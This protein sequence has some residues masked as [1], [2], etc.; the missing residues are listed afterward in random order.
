M[1][2]I[3]KGEEPNQNFPPTLLVFSSNIVCISLFSSKCKNFPGTRFLSSLFIP[4][5]EVKQISCLMSCYMQQASMQCSQQCNHSTVRL[6]QCDSKH[7][8]CC[9]T[10]YRQCYLCSSSMACCITIHKFYLHHA[11]LIKW[12]IPCERTLHHQIC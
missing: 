6:C 4:G 8:C 2:A 10:L 5:M 9:V 3:Y 11:W 12:L 1:S 7:E